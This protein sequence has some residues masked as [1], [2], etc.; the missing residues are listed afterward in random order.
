MPKA[1]TRTFSRHKTTE[2]QDT[3]SKPVESDLAEQFWAIDVRDLQRQAGWGV[4]NNVLN[5]AGEGTPERRGSVG[6]FDE[7]LLSPP[8]TPNRK[9]T[10]LSG[11]DLE[12]KLE[13]V[14]R[15]L[16]S[17]GSEAPQDNGSVK[18][19]K[20]HDGANGKKQGCCVII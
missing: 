3:V 11:E 13:N 12:K 15:V 18:L 6:S 5:S 20:A 2:L 1:G 10:A 14:G 8:P 16:Q 4:E 19:H 9:I 17:L 7:I